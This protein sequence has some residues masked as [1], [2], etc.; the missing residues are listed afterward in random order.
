MKNFKKVLALALAFAMVLSTMTISF[1]EEM[2]AGEKLSELGLVAGD[3]EGNLL[4]DEVLTRAQMMVM[5]ARLNGVE[6]EAMAY[7]GEASFTDVAAD[8]YYAPF[9]A[10]A[11]NAGWTNGVGDGLFAPDAEV[12][13]QMVATFTLRVLGYD[14]TWET[15]VED[16]AELGIMDD[17]AGATFTRANAFD[18]MYDA[19]MTEVAGGGQTL[20]QKLGVV[21][22]AMDAMVDTAVA[23]NATVVEVALDEDVDAPE[24]VDASVFMVADEDG[25]A[26]AVASAEFAPWD[27]DNYTV[28]VTLEDELTVG[29][30]YTVTSGDT[31]ANFGGK[32]ADTEEPTV[33]SV[34]TAYDEVTITFD[35]AV[36][37]E[38]LTVEINEKY[39]DKDELAVLDFAYDGNNAVVV[40]T[41]EQADATLYS[42]VVD[43]ATDV[44]GNAMEEDDTNTF[45]GE[46]FPT[47]DLEVDGA[48]SEDY[49]QVVVTFTAKVDAVDASSF[50]ITEKY[51]DKDELAVL[52]AVVVTDADD[53]DV[54]IDK[55]K[56]DMAVLLTTEAQADATLYTVVVEDVVDAFGNE[57]ADDQEETF[58][59]TEMPTDE[60]EIAKDGVVAQSNTTVDVTFAYDVDEDTF[61]AGSFTITE[62]YGDQD[63]LAVVGVE[64]DGAT[65][66]LTTE[67]QSEAT[68]YEIT[69]VDV[70]DI[71]GNELKDG[72]VT[73]TF[74][75]KAV[76]DAISKIDTLEFESGS[77]TELV[78]TFDQNVDDAALN[79]ALYNINKDIGYPEKVVAGDDDNQVVLTIPET[80]VGTVYTLTVAEG[81][82]NADGVASDD[83]ITK[84][85]AGKGTT[86]DLPKLEA[87]V[88]LN[89]QMLEVYF[90]SDV[91][92]EGFD[93]A[94]EVEIEIDGDVID[95]SEFT[96][97]E[98]PMD[99]NVLVI[100]APEDTFKEGSDYDT[101]TITVAACDEDN[102]EVDFA[103][104]DDD[105]T[106]VMIDGV[107]ALNN[108]TIRVY[109]N[110]YVASVDVAEVTI[111]DGETTIAA[112]N[113][114]ADDSEKM[115]Y[116]IALASALDKDS[117]DLV[118]ENTG[119]AINGNI[120][121][122]DD[123]DDM[124][125]EFA[126]TDEADSY[127]DSVYAVMVDEK[128]IEVYYPEAM[129]GGL[130]TSDY[131]LSYTSA[132]AITNVEWDDDLVVATL[133][134]DSTYPT[135]AGDQDTLTIPVGKVKNEVGV[136]SVEDEDGDA[137]TIDFAVSTKDAPEVA[138]DEITVTGSVITV[139][140]DQDVDASGADEA[141]FVVTV[142]G[143]V[144]A[145]A[146]RTLDD[147]TVDDAEVEITVTADIDAGAV[148]EVELN[149]STNITGLYDNEGLEDGSSAT[150]VK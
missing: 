133:T 2:T 23:L 60:L 72:E 38:D 91:T 94:A 9:I 112:V 109:F 37:I 46:A 5:L 28:L 82:L 84:T 34:E 49:N 126:G 25:T 85:F 76:A 123:S 47:A 40:T 65:V 33:S 136:K 137:V 100:V 135:S 130:S 95:D 97:Y 150:V 149:E 87:A 79:V 22:V 148:V 16:A 54:A 77:D 4:E 99:S 125:I 26:V 35:E 141:D 62:K 24:A 89:N 39:G 81:I 120:E 110:Q 105:A 116:D 127:I 104:N 143:T 140:F 93:N 3:G 139:V 107:V 56:D 142:D 102:D 51:G 71:Y 32:A 21:E 29:D 121:F 17:N 113:A 146:D 59:G 74:V 1:A 11:E 80:E 36:L 86:A 63:E 67:E 103:L 129:D 117:W 44:A 73:D 114:V 19:V 128:H 10:Y 144:V 134:L 18:M 27:A 6:A 48:E 58:V 118:V 83:D 8:S 108:K 75:G 68:L 45:V 90:D 101:A 69:I 147:V 98:N 52:D 42:V 13:A 145:V 66:T 64:T 50:T 96:F 14:V 53:T 132:P 61:D 31:S 70:Q 115:T 106:A 92:D 57:L 12:G 30:L 131:E 15:A 7:T 41:E 55:D 43:G 138:I 122:S 124:T 78:V 111:T 88:A 119:F 20:G